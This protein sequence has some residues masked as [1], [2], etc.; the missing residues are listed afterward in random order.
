MPDD[1]PRWLA[2]SAP[3]IRALPFGRY[4]IGNAVAGL[5]RTPFTARLPADLGAAAFECDLRDSIAREVCFTGRYEPQETTLALALLG[6]GMTVLDVGA[7]WGYFTLVAAHAVGPTGRVVALE[8]HPGLHAMLQRNV[9]ANRLA[10]VDC[11]RLAA[12]RSAGTARFAGFRDTDGNSGLSREVAPGGAFDFECT[13]C[14]ID[15]VADAHGLDAVDLVKIDIE[16]GEAEALAGMADGLRRGR[17]RRLLIEVHP[18]ALAERGSATAA[19]IDPL[20]RAGYRAWR[21]DHSPGMHR[22][23]ATGRAA[24]REFLRPLDP[25]TLERDDW[26]HLLWTAPGVPAP[27]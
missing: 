1:A 18:R 13:V 20:N 26:P 15:A 23:A 11:R 4:R 21:I 27:V 19:A 3:V 25:G 6:P 10:M 7:N 2:W 14:A 12:G 9:S 17:Y 8:P 22:R 5:A 16:G 24:L